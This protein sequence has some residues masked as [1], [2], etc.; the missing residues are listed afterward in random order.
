MALELSDKQVRTAIVL[1][2]LTVTAGFMASGVTR[3]TASSLLPLEGGAGATA[4][5]EATTPSPGQQPPDLKDILRRNIFDP[6]TGALWPPKVEQPTIVDDG[7][8]DVEAGDELPPGAMPPACEGK[9]KMV[10]S[11]YAPKRPDWSFV[12]LNT[13][14]GEPLL[15]RVGATVEGKTV[16]SI[17]PK[18]VFLKEASS[19]LCSVTMFVEAEKAKTPTR[20]SP[21][22]TAKAATSKSAKNDDYAKHIEK[23]SPTKYNVNRELVD[24]LL[25][26]QAELM[27]AARVVPHE[28][29]GQVVGVKLY[30]IRRKSLLGQL[31]L[32]NGDL[33]RTVNGF[34]MASPD[35]ALQA[36]AKLR[37][38]SN[39]SVAITRR[40]K[41]MNV[42]YNVGK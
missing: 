33:L 25:T 28:Q 11:V 31:G 22:T 35:S 5:A 2:T 7:S 13:G 39:L 34:D 20:S 15:Y 21:T 8:A 12:T 41:V 42:D 9:L 3:L 37:D 14:A 4:G 24:K 40:G 10:A 27:R 16:D 30:G 17:Y 23:V 29:N 1:T 32:Q 19:S 38:A 26:N 36:Y 6:Q 18:A